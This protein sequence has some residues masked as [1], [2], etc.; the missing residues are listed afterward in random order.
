[1]RE[2]TVFVSPMAG[3]SS[4]FRKVGFERPKFMLP[5]FGKTIFEFA[6]GSFA[7]YFQS[8]PFILITNNNQAAV[9][10]VKNQVAA[11]GITSVKYVAMDRQTAGQAETVALGLEACSITTDE[12]IAIF[13]IDSFRLNFSAPERA[14][15]RNADGYLEVFKG[16]GAHWSFAKV[17]GSDSFRV[18]ETAEKQRISD[19]CSNGF[20]YFQKAAE[21]LAAFEADRAEG[22]V[23]E[24]YIAPLYNRLITK[25]DDIRAYLIPESDT[26]FCGLPTEYR[27]FLLSGV[28]RAWD[29]THIE[30]DPEALNPASFKAALSADDLPKAMAILRAIGFG[31]PLT[32]EH[33]DLAV[34]LLG[35]LG[36]N[37][38]A[39]AIKTMAD[40]TR[41]ENMT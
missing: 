27:D 19:L 38:D 12:P 25:G 15:I 9:E 37:D 34:S 16:M 24:Y 18:T 8:S 6:I 41:L 40:Y 14:D 20:Y 4:R 39:A 5:A 2:G 3:E 23:G 28:A 21:F 31:H 36:R 29:I 7:A 30:V 11:L 1:M 13:N 17:S 32:T 26:E 35:T 10:F 33:L 22:T